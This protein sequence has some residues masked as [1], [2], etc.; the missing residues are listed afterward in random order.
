MV[1]SYNNRPK[2]WRWVVGTG[3]ILFFWVLIGGVLTAM[4]AS[5]FNL[6][7]SALAGTD[8][9]SRAI[10]AGYPTWQ[11]A[12]AILIS[13]APLLLATLLS[14]RYILGL[15]LRH[16]VT[17]AARLNNRRILRGALVMSLLLLVTS[18]PD[19]F[20]NPKDYS[21]T[22]KLS[23]F[24]PYLVVAILLIPMQTSAEESFYRGWIQQWLDN[25]RRP[26]W[27]IATF[28]GLLFSLPHLA[29]PEVN[30]ELVLAVIGYGATGFMFSWVT[31]RDRS[32]EVAL[33]AHAANNIL[34]GVLIT[35]ADSAL[36][37][38]SIWTSPAVSWGPAA[39]ISVAMVPI[40][41]WL[42]RNPADKVAA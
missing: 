32:M 31:F 8:E 21:Y 18:I 20:L 5:L 13:F 9:K 19:L 42:T 12:I 25:G 15:P 22:F 41:I 14:Y 30:G 1:E 36:P 38:S 2:A 37:S 40:F 26:I 10:L 7:L 29:N 39:V 17:S 6:D 35:S 28:N 27:V 24:L 23:A 3:A 4:T 11:S 33:G 34:A 16:L